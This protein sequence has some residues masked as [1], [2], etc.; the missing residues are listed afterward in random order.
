MSTAKVSDLH[1]RIN[2]INSIISTLKQKNITKVVDMENYFFDN[3]TELMNTYPFLVSHLCS[4]GDMNM[5]NVMLVEIDKVNKGQISS[6]DADLNIGH[7]LTN[8]YVKKN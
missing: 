3:H 7:K 6:A 5:L 1:N 8:T 2:T 4:G